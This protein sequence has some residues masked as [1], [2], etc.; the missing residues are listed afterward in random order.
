SPQYSTVAV[1]RNGALLRAWQVDD[2]KWRL[3]ATVDSIDRSYIDQLVAYEDGRFRDHRGVDF[4]A[5]AR[6]AW[7]RARRGRVV[8]GASTLTMQVAR[9]LEDMPTGSL[10]AK[11]RQIRLALALE[12]TL[13]KDEILNLYLS[14]A[15]FGGNIEGIRSASLIWFGKEPK[16]LTPAEAALLVALPQSPER[17][18]PD[19]HAQ[20][21]RSARDRVLDRILEK[22]VL[23]SGEV[24]AAK[25]EPV[26]ADRRRFPRLAAHLAERERRDSQGSHEPLI[27]LTVDAGLQR[28]LEDLAAERAAA[29]PSRASIAVLA[30]DHSTGHVVASVGSP[31]LEH[32]RR[33]GFLD[34]TRAVRSPGSTL[35]PLIYGLAFDQGIAHPESLIEDRPTTFGNY[36]PTNFNDGY[37]GTVS[38][39]TAL[40]RSLNVPAVA[41]LDGIGPARLMAR[42]RRA[43][44]RPVL[45]PGRQP[46]LAIGLGGVGVTLADLVAIYAAIAR[47]GESMGL[48][49]RPDGAAPAPARHVLSA[50]AAWHVSDILAGAPAPLAA[51]NGA[52]AFKTGTSYGHRDAWAI[53]Y[54]GKH[55]VGV[56]IGRPDAAPMPGATGIRTAAPVLFEA[57]SR[58]APVIA[59]LAG[60]P[61][62]ALTVAHGDL[63]LPLR[64]VRTPA[65]TPPE[66]R[67]T[68]AFPPNGARIDLRGGSV[69]LVLKLRD[70]R[71]PFSWLVNSAPVET[72]SFE[73]EAIWQPDTTG[74]VTIAVIDAAGRSA[75]SRVYVD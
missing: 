61:R 23:S 21:A 52:I 63:P 5:L 56:W 29:L 18:R 15:P 60:P 69:P 46:G 71:P 64:R 28:S 39:R 73:R 45:P 14:L 57:F 62:D 9:L 37:H 27:R 34:M 24:Q 68:I 30:V 54:D 12:R 20:A 8:S 40:Q 67:L 38:L 43:G 75:Q 31:G 58:L 50:G 16:R 48:L 33:G 25:R 4:L 35:K 3:A 32:A 36:T 7:Q 47:G 70:G 13:S 65:G 1:D 51:R 59:P 66:D 19:R 49:T 72:S 26:P 74:H 6:A 2:G 53:G 11:V 41:L 44:A 55:V 17:R 42:M 22:G 10:R